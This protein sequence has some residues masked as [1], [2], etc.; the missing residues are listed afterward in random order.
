MFNSLIRNKRLILLLPIFLATALL[1]TPHAVPSALA[2]FTGLVCITDTTTATSCSPSP[3]SLGPFSVGQNFTVGVFVQGSDA[4]GSFEIYVKS[5]PALVNPVSAALGSLIA[6][7]ALSDM[8]IDN[9][10]FTVN[11]C[12]PGGVNGPGVVQVGATERTGTNECGGVSPC[13]GMAFTI[14]YN[15]VGEAMQTSLFYP[16]AAS[17]SVNSVSSQPNTCVVI[18]NAVR[19]ILPESIQ[20]ATVAQTRFTGLV[21]VTFPSN[22]TSCPATPP[23][24]GPLSVGSSFT[25]GIFLQGSDA[26]GGYDIYVRSDPAVVNPTSAAVG[27]LI[28][29]PSLTSICVNGVAQTGACTVGFANGPGVVE[30]TT[31]ESSGTNECGGISPCSGMAF[32]IT[33]TVVPATPSTSLTYPTNAS[34]S[35]S[36]VSSPPNTCVL[37]AD[38]TG[39]TLSENIQGATVN[40]TPVSGLVCTTLPATSTSCPVGTPMIGPLAVGQNLTVGV[41][42]QNSPPLAGFDIYVS[43]NPNYLSPINATLGNLITNAVFPVICING[44]AVNGGP[45]GRANGPGIVEVSTIEGSGLNDPGTGLAFSIT[46]RIVHATL[47]TP[48][49]YPPGCS[50]SSND[51]LCVFV[52]NSI[53]SILPVNV[54]GATVF[55]PILVDPTTT[56]V[57]CSPNPEFVGSETSCT[58][59]VT[60]TS[61]SGATAPTGT[62]TWSTSDLGSFTCTIC[63]LTS[64]DT[65]QSAFGTFY[66]PLALG[67]TNI[68]ASY[69]GDSTH[70][71]SNG[72]T[73]LSVVKTTPGLST[74]VLVDQTGFL[75]P[76]T[77]VPFGLSVHDNALLVA[78]FPVTGVTGS[79]SY[80]LYPNGL[81]IS[82][83]G[84]VVST[85]VVS[86]ANNV[87]PS[88]SVTPNATGSWSFN[89]MYSGDG[90]NNPTT[91]ACEPFTVVPAPSFTAGKLHWTHHVSLSKNSNAQSWTAMV[92]N[93]LPATAFVVV[94]IVG[95]STTNPAH[96]FDVTCGVTCV[97]TVGGDVNNTPGL[98]PVSVA[99]GTTSFSFSFN[100]PISSSF[101]NQKISFTA[102][103][104]WT[105]GTVYS[106]SDSKSGT[107][108]V[109]P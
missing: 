79:V 7:P 35:T 84:T 70:S 93:P 14:T 69:S 72:C 44:A 26:M 63:T 109:T 59:I 52:S 78:G 61:S 18:V 104:Y 99:A 9:V 8:C 57:V 19:T 55:T 62:V 85:V 42:V 94:R 40:I 33:Y 11:Q 103:L 74:Y 24:I 25:V 65:F 97:N 51:S 10:S 81:C 105:T 1:V 32:T 86:F 54:Q 53:G 13:S 41:F 98:T 16:T 92:A 15:V 89:A 2:Q 91:S 31:I 101:V 58:G 80:A 108:A 60:D 5:Y 64:I 50:G 77:G 34:C 37:V 17:C 12:S 76:A 56:A 83:T 107:F 90:N 102:T 67:P 30:A 36:S 43:V 27:S 95:L 29:T 49:Y 71:S 38:A 66:T 22:A 73:T 106:P 23:S 47:G 68:C 88:S 100:Q 21:C 4:M 48:I 3:P 6:H 75:V 87:P 45:C 46:Y 39:T 20:G 28:V 96:T 82:G